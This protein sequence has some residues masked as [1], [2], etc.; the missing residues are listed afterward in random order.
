MNRFVST[1]AVANVVNCLKTGR[2]NAITHHDL[3]KKTGLNDR[4][5]RKALEVARLDYCIINN[6]DGKGYYLAKTKAE[7]ERYDRQEKARANAI[8]DVEE[9]QESF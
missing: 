6:Q 3:M 2:K 5:L 4:L 1:E 9:E 8:I 7:A